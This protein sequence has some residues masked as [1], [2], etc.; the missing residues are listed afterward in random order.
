MEM[1][2]HVIYVPSAH[3]FDKKSSCCNKPV[4]WEAS[5]S[6]REAVE[7]DTRIWCSSCESPLE[8]RFLD[9]ED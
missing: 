5:R 2:G 7:W 1:P 8:Q 3:G 6:I 4:N 9:E